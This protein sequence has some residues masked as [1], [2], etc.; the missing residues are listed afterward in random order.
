MWA[1]VVPT[2]MGHLTV[3]TLRRAVGNASFYTVV[4]ELDI[5]AH[6]VKW[7]EMV[8]VQRSFQASESG[9]DEAAR[10][11]SESMRETLHWALVYTFENAQ[12]LRTAQ[13]SDGGLYGTFVRLHPTA[14]K[15]NGAC[16]L[17]PLDMARVMF[18]TPGAMFSPQ[19][20]A[21]ITRGLS[22]RHEAAIEGA[23]TVREQR[24]RQGKPV[25]RDGYA[26]RAVNPFPPNYVP[27]LGGR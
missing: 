14:F 1:L 21:W 20:I 5:A 4:G 22:E 18:N 3:G 26:H 10:T 23:R 15:A 11:Y 25:T 17:N 13:A 2:S 27:M 16:S 12:R 7:I 8:G 19:N 24:R 6:Q 9:Y